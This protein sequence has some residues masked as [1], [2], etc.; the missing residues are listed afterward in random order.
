LK[1]FRKTIR[2]YNKTIF[3]TKLENLDK[4]ADFLD[5]YQVP[6]LNQDQINYLESLITPKEIKKKTFIRSLPTKMKLKQK[7]TTTTT[8]QT[9]KPRARWFQCSFKKT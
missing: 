6:R 4:L 2:S 5:R 1:K 8:K 3:S 7:T 9:N